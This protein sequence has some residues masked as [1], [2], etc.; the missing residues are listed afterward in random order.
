[1]AVSPLRDMF[2]PLQFL[3]L[4]FGVVFGEFEKVEAAVGA[5]YGY[6]KGLIG[7]VGEAFLELFC[8]AFILDCFKGRTVSESPG[9]EFFYSLWQNN[10]FNA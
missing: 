9:A 2:V 5:V 6:V 4:L 3:Q 8:S 10:F 7:V 1:M